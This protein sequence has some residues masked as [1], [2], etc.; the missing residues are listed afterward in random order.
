MRNI[1]RQSSSNIVT[2]G[3][4]RCECGRAVEAYDPDVDGRTLKL[5]CRAC[6]HDQLEVELVGVDDKI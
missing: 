1:F 6:H 3:R 2:F 4:L 5:I